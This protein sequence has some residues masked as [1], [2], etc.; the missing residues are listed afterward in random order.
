LRRQGAGHVLLAEKAV[1]DQFAEDTARPGFGTGFFDLARGDESDILED[2]DDVFF[3]MGH[4][5]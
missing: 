2:L 3:V 4:D 5:G 1:V